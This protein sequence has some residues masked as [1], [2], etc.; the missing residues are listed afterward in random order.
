MV[1]VDSAAPMRGDDRGTLH[2]MH[3]VYAL[4]PGGMEFGIV[5]LVNG[6]DRRRIRPSIL[7]TRPASKLKELLLPD[8]QLFELTRRRG[9]DPR[10]IWQMY[11]VFRAARPDVVHTHAW[12]TL[13]EGL[14]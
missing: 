6:H 8:V 14:V 2:V 11:R 5:K 1:N 10:L 3:V 4:Q 9:N 12:G 13:V 7:S